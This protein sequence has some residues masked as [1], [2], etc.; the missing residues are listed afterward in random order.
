MNDFV[1][2][3]MRAATLLTAAGLSTALVTQPA[4]AQRV[5][6]KIGN[7]C[8]LGYVDTFNGKCSTFGLVNYT[9]QPTNG[10][11]CRSGWMNVGGGYCRKK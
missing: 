9:L 2:H 1:P 6:R 5:V 4:H 3:L 11:A 8:P 7:M 10:Q